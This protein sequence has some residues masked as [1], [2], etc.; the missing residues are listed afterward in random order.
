[1]MSGARSAVFFIY[2]RRVS[3]IVLTSAFIWRNV[4]SMS[5]WDILP[6]GGGGNCLELSVT[7]ERFP[8]RSKLEN[9]LKFIIVIYFAI[10]LLTYCRRRKPAMKSMML[11]TTCKFLQRRLRKKYV[12]YVQ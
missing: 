1:M 2:S 10:S 7:L 8:L 11:Q 12:C 5:S 6:D 4:K 3:V 9:K